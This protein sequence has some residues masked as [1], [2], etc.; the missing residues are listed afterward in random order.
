[1]KKLISILLVVLLALSVFG[2]AAQVN[3]EPI[4]VGSKNF[5][6][7]QIL[8][9]I[10]Y[11]MLEANDFEVVNRLN[12]GG[13]AVNRDAL[14]AGEIHVYPEYTGTALITLLPGEV[15]GF[16]A[17][18]GVANDPDMSFTTVSALDG[19]LHD[20]VWLPASPA[21]NVYALAVM[22]DFA[23]EHGLQTVGDFADYVNAGNEVMLMSNDEFAQRPDGLQSFEQT[24]GFEITD[25]EMIVLAGAIPAQTLQALNDGTDGVNVAM[26]FGT[27]GVLV[28]YD[29]ILL[30]DTDG[31]Q[32][33]YSNAPVFRGEVIRAH[34]EII[35]ILTPVFRLLDDSTQQ[36][37]NA[38]VDVDGL[39]AQDVARDFLVEHGFLDG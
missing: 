36:A 4:V 38:A 17:P 33:V 30:E 7:N 6:E 31:A 8:G 37:L 25:D 22:A 39:P 2:A 9:W 5:T 19:T 12:L 28:A 11:Q 1:M 23:A 18:E 35:A 16:A 20:L 24:Y 14:L 27:A 13:T 32:P 10:I 15:E 3:D 29:M 34:P 21:N 26:A